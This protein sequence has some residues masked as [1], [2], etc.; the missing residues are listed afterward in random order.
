MAKLIAISEEVYDRL[1]RLKGKEK[2]KSFTAVISELLRQREDDIEDLFGA[3][4]M[5]D[6]EAS[7]LKRKLREERTK[8]FSGRS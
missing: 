2:A 5:N 7:E 4:K 6:K 3:W 1:S 8:L